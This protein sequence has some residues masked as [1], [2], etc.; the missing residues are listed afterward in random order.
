MR[1]FDEL[2]TAILEL[3]KRLN[4]VSSA[5]RGQTKQASLRSSAAHDRLVDGRLTTAVCGEFKSGKSTL[6][7]AL[8]DEPELFPDDTLPATN[9]VTTV[10]WGAVETVTVTIQISDDEV[11]KIPITRAEIKDYVTE[12][13]NPGNRRKVLLVDIQTPNPKLASGLAFVDTPGVGGVFSEHT[14]V[15]LAFL[16][17]ADALLFITDAEKPLLQSELDFL[18][19]A[20]DVAKLTDDLD[21]VVCVMTKIDQGTGFRKLFG[22]TRSKLA[23][24]T[25][26]TEESVVLIPVSSWQKLEYLADGDPQSLAF[27]NF[28]A[29][30]EAL[31]AA[32]GRR[33]ARVLLGGALDSL[34]EEALAYLLPIEAAQ[35]SAQDQ[36]GATL[37]DLQRQAEERRDHLARLVEDSAGWKADLTAEIKKAASRVDAVAHT[38]LEKNWARFHATYVY[39][40]ELLA[41]PPLLA[42]KLD[43]DFSA[44]QGGLLKLVRREVAGATGRFSNRRG[45]TIDAPPISE[46]PNLPPPSMPDVSNVGG[47]S[48]GGGVVVARY[49]SAAAGI[50]GAVGS[51]LGGVLGSVF[52]PGAGTVAGV[53]VGAQWGAAVCTAIGGFLGFRSARAMVQVNNANNQRAEVIRVFSQAKAGQKDHLRLVLGLAFDDIRPAALAELTGRLRQ[54]KE[55]TGNILARLADERRAAEEDRR[56]DDERFAAEREPLDAVLAE[57]KL[58]RLNVDALGGADPNSSAPTGA[59]EKIDDPVDT[60]GTGA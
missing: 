38:E 42:D 23:E 36:S 33:R 13:G 35:R 52:A 9:A 29:L 5:A 40:P 53:V 55:T 45:F 12:G 51:V 18:R 26:Q 58:L 49:A 8:L 43:A 44:L 20:I 28:E 15:T 34:R 11:E 27:S 6:L 50:G 3:F 39:D 41:N 19:R 17:G 57:V 1:S 47:G 21:S 4:A 24:F 48:R 14:A 2:R 10:R 7:S 37:A 56:A 31:W 25:G 30:E 16:P 46:L 59:Q 60:D 54:E 22:E 32:L